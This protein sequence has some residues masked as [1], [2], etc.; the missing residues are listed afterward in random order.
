[1]ADPN[2]GE[3]VAA[4]YE[5]VYPDKPEDNFFYSNALWYALGE[6]G[7]KL[8]RDGGRLFEWPLEFAANTT[9]AMVNEYEA[10]STTVVP[11]FD[12]ARYDQKTAA[13]TV[14]YSV[15]EMLRNQGS[16]RAKFDL[17]EGRIENGRK[18]H[19]NLLNTQ[20]WST[21]VPGSKDL[22]SIPT[23]VA[24]DPTVGIVGGI[25]G[26]TFPWWRNR[27]NSGAA[28]PT[29]GTPFE[30]LDSAME[31][32]FNQCSLGGFDMTPTCA[33]SGIEVFTGYEGSLQTRLR[34]FVEDLGKNGD[35]AFLANAIRYKAIPFFYD[36]Q[37]NGAGSLYF[38]NNKVLRFEYLDGA[39][40][41]LDAAIMPAN[42]LENVHR[43]YT[44]G[45]FCC[46][47]RRHLGVVTGIN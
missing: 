4:T 11:V 13:G 19:R 3:Q 30:N 41:K 36:E 42:I 6:K 26:A 18:S 45:N 28:T 37:L 39:W 27:Q 25:N 16:P 46:G 31:L 24:T 29:T 10:L 35:S 47:A 5:D 32:T 23:I 38:L 34:Y 2:I 22:T 7:F 12:A 1:M 14:T 15:Q 44:V 8:S 21:A 33:I 43:I 40:A 9:M 17:I 20:A